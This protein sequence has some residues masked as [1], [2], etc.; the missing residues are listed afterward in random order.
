MYILDK[1]PYG[2]SWGCSCEGLLG[3]LLGM[4]CS[5][6]SFIVRCLEKC[7]MFDSAGSLNSTLFIQDM[8]PKKCQDGE[9]SD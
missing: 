6:F 1:G 7:Q 9:E 8:V 2:D 5:G 3:W 4:G